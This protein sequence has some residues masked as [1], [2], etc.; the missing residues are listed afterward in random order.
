MNALSYG[1]L[2]LLARESLSGYDLMRKIQ[3][4][5]QVGHSQIYPLLAKLENKELVMYLLVQQTDKPDKKV[6]SITD[7]G[8]EQLKIWVHQT[9]EEATDR[10]ELMF[11]T[12]CIWLTDPEGAK[13][14]FEERTALYQE[15]LRYVEFLLEEI[16]RKSG[17]ELDALSFE[18][19][20]FGIYLILKKALLNVHSNLEWCQFAIEKCKD[21]NSG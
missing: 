13:R 11:K 5:W 14:L 7:K 8:L 4:F 10:D 3:P 1:L 18:S 21:N 2:S 9:T 20:Y 16:Q 15:R 6:Y 17:Q 12:Y 19:R